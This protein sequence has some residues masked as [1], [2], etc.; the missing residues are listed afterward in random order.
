MPWQLEHSLTKAVG[1]APGVLALSQ[2]TATGV[3]GPMGVEPAP[4]PPVD[5][6]VTEPALPVDGIVTEPAPPVDG[7]IPLPPPAPVSL[8]VGVGVPVGVEPPVGRPDWP[9]PTSAPIMKRLAATLT[10]RTAMSVALTGFR[11]EI[12]T[13]PSFRISP[14]RPNAQMQVASRATD[15]ST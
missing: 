4:A 2:E 6:I 7:S 13:S 14:T 12:M 8:G 9:Q 15:V 3:I 10:V 1:A 5:G 11:L